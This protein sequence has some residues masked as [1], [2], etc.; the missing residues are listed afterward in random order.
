MRLI[1]GDLLVGNVPRVPPRP[2][3][4]KAYQKVAYADAEAVD[5]LR[6]VMKMT[7]GL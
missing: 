5:L 2:A 6:R 7:G 3:R 1:A 4:R